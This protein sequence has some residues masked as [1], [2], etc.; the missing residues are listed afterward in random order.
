[1]RDTDVPDPSPIDPRRAARRAVLIGAGFIACSL[2]A[3]VL[4]ALLGGIGGELTKYAVTIAFIGACL[5]LAML[6]N[7]A[8]DWWRTR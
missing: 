5:G 1:M 6:L 4:L 2:I 3:M 8:I 7:G